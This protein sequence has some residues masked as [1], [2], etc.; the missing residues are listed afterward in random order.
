MGKKQISPKYAQEI[1]Q[2]SQSLLKMPK[3]PRA[4]QALPSP[5][6][7]TRGKL[8]RIKH[9]DSPHNPQKA[10]SDMYASIQTDGAFMLEQHGL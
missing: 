3:T 9:P 6:T 10:P 7:P 8:T 1:G 5:A 4:W 2:I